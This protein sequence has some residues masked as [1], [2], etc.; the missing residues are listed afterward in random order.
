M[1]LIGIFGYSFGTKDS[2]PYPRE[3]ARNQKIINAA[4]KNNFDRSINANISVVTLHICSFSIL[5][6]GP[7]RADAFNMPSDLPKMI[8]CIK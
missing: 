6:N 2:T 1:S 4:G 5:R 7:L 8:I 3:T